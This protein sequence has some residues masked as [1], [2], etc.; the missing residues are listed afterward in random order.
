MADQILKTRLYAPAEDENRPTERKVLYPETNIESIISRRDGTN[1]KDD[2]GHKIV[3]SDSS[4]IPDNEK[5]SLTGRPVFF[6]RKGL[7]TVT[8]YTG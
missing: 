2:I 7:G 5:P 4:K 3:T 6:I 1:L 8:D